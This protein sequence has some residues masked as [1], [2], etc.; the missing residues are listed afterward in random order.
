M[1]PTAQP[2]LS[3]ELGSGFGWRV[4]PVTRQRALHTGLDF[5]AD[6]GTP[7]CAATGDMMVTMEYH[8]ACG[9][10][11]EIDHG[12]ELVTRY[13]HTSHVFAK[14][15]DIVKRGQQIASVGST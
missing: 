6:V 14:V 5:S 8:P 1:L 15:G 10:L 7:I 9:H 12:N 2:A 13:A 4:D 11:I 3:G